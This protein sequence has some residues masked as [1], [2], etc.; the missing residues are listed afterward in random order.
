MPQSFYDSQ[1][2]MICSWVILQHIVELLTIVFYGVK[3]FGSC[4]FLE[5]YG[6]KCFST[7]AS[8]YFHLSVGATILDF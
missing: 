8:V 1:H 4:L 7:S 6:T 3:I 5:K 2:F